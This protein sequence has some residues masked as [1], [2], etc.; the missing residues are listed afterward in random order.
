MNTETT[1][2]LQPGM[3]GERERVLVQSGGLSAVAFRYDTGVCGLRLTSDVG[4]L[5]LSRARR[6]LEAG[7]D[8]LIAPA[9]WPWRR[10][11]V[12]S[13][14]LQAR[15]IENGVWVM[16][17]CIAGSVF[18]GEDFAGAGN[19]V[20][21]PLG[22]EVRTADDPLPVGTKVDLRFTIIVDDFETIEGIG[23]VVRVVKPSDSEQCGMGVVFT[24]LAS[25]SKALIDRLL[26]RNHPTS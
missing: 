18:E 24:E 10:D 2:H 4:E 23:E 13:T 19:H 21:D 25:Y 15:A 20:F 11:W 5:V 16:G 12:W 1:F 8:M 3:F 14:L 26:T 6:A 17:C 7:C 22:E 9:W